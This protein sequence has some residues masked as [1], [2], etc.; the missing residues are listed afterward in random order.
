MPVN[1]AVLRQDQVD[2]AAG[3][4]ARAFHKDPL[5]EYFFP[6]PGERA[7]KLPAFFCLTIR[8]GLSEGVVTAT[9]D[10]LEAVSIW[11]PPDKSEVS[12][13]ASVRT[14]A[15]GMA[16]EVGLGA[17][18]RMWRFSRSA[19]SIRGRRAPFNHWV[20][21][22]VGVDPKLQGKGY[23]SALLRS[24]LKIL[25]RHHMPCYL[26]TQSERNVPFYEHLGFSV[27]QRF[28]LPGTAIKGWAMLR[29]HRL[30]S[31]SGA[32]QRQGM[33]SQSG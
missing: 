18:S 16:V 1:P 5:F 9:S 7:R 22:T 10:R 23:A 15:L 8:R 14:G 28:N 30:D 31:S 29:N 33:K 25:D 3:M 21:Q 27:A 6:D 32:T 4:L 2:P 19:E 11:F 24:Q 26:D 20:L 17:V 13:W 12:A